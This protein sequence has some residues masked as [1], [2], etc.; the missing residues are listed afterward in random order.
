MKTPTQSLVSRAPKIKGA[1][2]VFIPLSPLEAQE[3][4]AFASEQVRSRQS[5]C[6]SMYLIGINAWKKE[7]AIS[8]E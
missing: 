1:I 3:A 2:R 7:R 6:R 5:F 4:D 8:P